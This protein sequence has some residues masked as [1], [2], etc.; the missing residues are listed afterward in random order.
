M[1]GLLGYPVKYIQSQDSSR[2]PL[3]AHEAVMTLAPPSSL[4]CHLRHRRQVLSCMTTNKQ[5]GILYIILYLI[6]YISAVA[7]SITPSIQVENLVKTYG[8]GT[9]AV[10]GI[11]FD[12][13]DGESY[14]FLG[15][16]GAG[17]TT[18]IKIL[19][20]VW[21]KTAG[22]AAVGGLDVEKNAQNVRKLIGVQMQETV[23]DEDLTGRENLMLQGHLQQMH[24]EVLK[25]RGNE[26]LKSVYL[27]EAADKRSAFYSRGIKKRLYRPSN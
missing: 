10:K 8:D 23:I 1:S 2:P 15:P 21:K 17:K 4:L 25:D 5:S 16:N 11:T 12:V 6:R 20:T 3:R 9:K 27:Q 13:R 19:T 22:Q 18:T 14:G 7:M 24:G 26:I